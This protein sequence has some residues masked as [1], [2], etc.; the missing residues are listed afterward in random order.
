M[1]GAP[2]PVVPPAPQADITKPERKDG[3]IEGISVTDPSQGH[4]NANLTKT[5]H[6]AD[7]ETPVGEEMIAIKR[8]Y[9][10]AGESI[11]EEKVV[12]KCSA[13]ARLYL[14]SQRAVPNPSISASGTKPP[15]RRPKKRASMF[16][17]KPETVG[18]KGGSPLSGAS[19]EKGPKL[20]TIE[21]SKL[22]W[23]GY[24]DKEGI[25]EELDVAEKAKDGY[26]GKVDFLGRVD[27]KREDQLSSARKK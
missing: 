5:T 20:N 6:E 27:A 1:N 19:K 17:P 9:V 25:K 11:T 26:L 7:A 14:E 13:E 22:D 8:T 21:K 15:L 12:P 18:G 23:A 24:V 16:D 10:F 4:D 3:G 2:E